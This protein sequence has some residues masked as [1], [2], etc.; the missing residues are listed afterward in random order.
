MSWSF[1]SEIVCPLFPQ[2]CL[3]RHIPVKRIFDICFSITALICGAPLFLLIA[4][5]IRLSSQGE[6]FYAHERVGRG[7]KSFKCYK[8]RTMYANSD[9]RLQK[10]LDK[11]PLL[12]KEWEETYK[13]K[14]DPRI[15]PVGAFLRKTSLDELPQFFNVITGELSVVGP[16][17]LV[18]EEVAQYLGH[19]AMKILSVRPGLTGLWQTS[20]RSN[21]SYDTRIRLDEYYINHQSFL[22]DLVLII[23]TIPV[24]IF[25][26]GA[27]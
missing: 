8:F 25:C 21:T 6:S 15:T 11:D 4:L 7:G 20:G 5:A 27:Y 9:K 19:K 10:L 18:R 12:K 23:K 24:M 22:F 17:A 26:R 16:R 13:L 2:G 1:P 3:V 14:N